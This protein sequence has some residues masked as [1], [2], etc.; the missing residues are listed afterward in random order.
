VW[1]EW[2]PLRSDISTVSDDVLFSTLRLIEDLYRADI[3]THGERKLSVICLVN[4]LADVRHGDPG[5][6][7]DV[8]LVILGSGTQGSR[9]DPGG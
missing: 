3:L 5:H 2:Q 6:F 8:A 7:L 9:S 4:N 1:E